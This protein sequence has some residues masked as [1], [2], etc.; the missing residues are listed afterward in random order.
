MAIVKKYIIVDLRKLYF[1]ALVKFAPGSALVLVNM[2]RY[3]ILSSIIVIVV[4]VIV[5]SI[6]FR[7]MGILWDII[8]G[9]FS[10]IF[11][12]PTGIALLPIY[13]KCKIDEI[14]SGA[15]NARNLKMK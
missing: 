8:S 9:I 10:T 13:S 6:F 15:R 11:Y 2:L 14:S 7:K 12:F 4:P 3:F 1:N 5:Y